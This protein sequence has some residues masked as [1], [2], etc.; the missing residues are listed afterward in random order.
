M[1]YVNTATLTMD[2]PTITIAGVG[3]YSEAFKTSGF[4]ITPTAGATV[5]LND[6]AGDAYKWGYTEGHRE[7]SAELLVDVNTQ[8]LPGGPSQ[9]GA[10][11]P[12]T[13]TFETIA[14]VI[15]T[16]SAV[17]GAGQ[18]KTASITFRATTVT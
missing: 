3:T 14:Y 10:E 13:F 4:T 18:F 15:L 9:V 11:S 17:R 12:Y 16:V 2:S 5:D 6:E 1:A 8:A 7:G